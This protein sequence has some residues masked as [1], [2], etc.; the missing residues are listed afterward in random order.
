MTQI[1][2]DKL[3]TQ[4]RAKTLPKEQWTHNAHILVAF[5]YNLNFEFDV[6]FKKIKENIWS[7]NLAV[8]TQNTDSGGYHETLTMFWMIYTRNYIET[9]NL[10]TVE[11]AFDHFIANKGVT[12]D[13]PL[14]YYSRELLF[15]VQARKECVNGDIKKL[16]RNK[17]E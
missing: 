10:E 7:Y 8:G 16:T 4:F 6:A 3:I 9:H 11:E 12:N 17:I 1:Q 13:L 5:W 15:S 14:R 2:I